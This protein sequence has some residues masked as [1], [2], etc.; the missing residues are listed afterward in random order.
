ML[1]RI[2]SPA[3][4]TVPPPLFR[5]QCSV[6]SVLFLLL[7]PATLAAPPSAD[8]RTVTTAHFRVHYPA[9]YEA[10]A[11]RAASRLE[12]IR[13][14]VAREVGFAPPQIIDVLVE[15]PRAESNGSA[16]PLLDTPR[17]I[18]WT[19][20]PGP[21][22]QLGAYGHWI[23]V[24]AVHE[25]AHLVHMLRP[26][27][28]PLTHLLEKFVVPF[29]PI[30]LRAPRWVLEGYATVIEGRLTGAGRPSST[31]R[32]L[33]LRRWAENG[34]LPTYGQLN[35]DRRFLGMSMAY[36]AGSAYLE[37][38]E[39][40]SRPGALRDLW[41]RMTARHRRSF[42][43]AF[44]GVFGESPERL[45][46]RFTAELTASALAIRRSGT[47]IEG[48]L[49]QETPRASGDPAVSPDGSKIAF[50]IRRR[51][52]PAKL[53]VWSTTD[54]DEGERQFEERLAKI[55]ARDPEDVAPVRVKPLPREPLHELVMPDGGD[56]ET[57]RWTPDG[58]T[59]VFAHRMPDAAGVLHFDLF[60]WDFE[61]VRRITTLADVRDAD[62]RP[63]GRSAVAVRSRFGASQLVTVDLAN[64]TVT[65]RAEASIE[66]VHA[67]PRVR[68][69]GAIAWLEHAEGGWTL[70]LD[71]GDG[72]RTI[73][74]A[75]P[76]EKGEPAAIA[77]QGDDLIASLFSRGFA[78]LHRIP[79][80]GGHPS[81]IEPHEP[82]RADEPLPPPQLPAPSSQLLLPTQ[83]TRTTG[84]AFDPAPAPDGRIFFTSLDPEGFVLR[85]LEPAG[86]AAAW[87]IDD[88]ALIPAI[89]PPPPVPPVLETRSVSGPQPYG[90]GRQEL[91][92]LAGQ[93]LGPR[94]RA[95]EAGVRLGDVV[96][97]LDTLLLGSFAAD[98]LPEGVALATAWRGWPVEVGLH[99]WTAGDEGDGIELRA[100]WA[101]RFP[102]SRLT[103]DAGASS[104]EIVFARGR[105][106]LQ[107][108]GAGRRFD[109][110][111]EIALDDSHWR[112]AAAATF[113]AGSFRLGVEARHDAG[114]AVSLGGLASSILPR[115]AYVRRVLD[116]ALPPDLATGDGYDGWRV[117]TKVPGAPFTAF[118][119]RHETGA[120]RFALAGAG[121]ELETAPNPILKLPAVAVTAGV[122][123]LVDSVCAGGR[124]CVEKGDVQWWLGMVWRP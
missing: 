7:A 9:P 64:G 67:S 6:F 76:G 72:V 117:E 24:L 21:D 25:T 48:N 14:E 89:P 8:W 3:S 106:A 73:P 62:P 74:L 78:E 91:T 56:I 32:A 69:D 113:T 86:T 13:E 68:A 109:E 33:I 85:V 65:P 38:L 87:A 111:I 104:D 61:R 36:L 88:A 120:S 75:P 112:I 4:T 53:V 84:G 97:R 60:A 116:P 47:L 122:A 101:R 27:R 12:S 94:Q 93:N 100:A 123:T 98:R 90:I 35:S 115:S 26:S 77:W 2:D 1:M 121:I 5:A 107:Q 80:D 57:P 18:F 15:N 71:A 92:W 17:M 54:A 63:D 52:A 29:N 83:L 58:R 118:Y 20:P 50:V 11:R 55:L 34:R 103:L 10:W 114:D 19:E 102:S 96:G 108:V 81:R 105:Y 82:S 79:L 31:L 119:H 22:E 49:F 43:D 39:E 110:A 37:W 95:I 44:T 23:D 30:T 51:D 28:N 40:R 99:A 66:R 124:A 41:A 46:G 59:L 70:R 16:W 45:Y 42:D